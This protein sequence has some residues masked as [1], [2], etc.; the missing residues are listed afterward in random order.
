MIDSGAEMTLPWASSNLRILLFLIPVLA[1]RGAVSRDVPLAATAAG[2]SSP[3][4]VSPTQ[5]ICERQPYSFC[6]DGRGA[7]RSW[8]GAGRLPLRFDGRG[9]EAVPRGGGWQW[10]LELAAWGPSGGET[11][12]RRA[13]RPHARGARLE[14]SHDGIVEWFVQGKDGLEHG[15]TIPRR[16]EGASGA[17]RVALR[18]RGALVGTVDRDGQTVTFQTVT[19]KA[20]IRYS[21]LIVTDARG[22][23]LPARMET[24]AGSISIRFDDRGATYPV[25]VDPIVQQAYL[26]PPTVNGGGAFGTAVAVSGNTVVVSNGDNKGQVIVFVRNA[27]V[28]SQQARLNASAGAFRDLFGS[29]VAISAN[30]LVVGA[31]GENAAYVFVRN[32]TTWTQQARL[33]NSLA[34]SGFGLSV[35]ASGDTLAV[36][37]YGIVYVYTRANGV[38]SQQTMLKGLEQTS[39][40]RRLFGTSVSLSGSTLVVGSPGDPQALRGVTFPSPST[41]ADISGA[42][43]VFVRSGANWTR[44]AY[45]KASNA[46]A[47]DRFGQ[48]V[49]ISGDTIVVGAP[50]EDS[51]GTGAAAVETLSENFDRACKQM[52]NP[53]PNRNCGFQYDNTATDAGAAYVFVR[54]GGAWSQQAYLK[55]SNT[56]AGDNFG[57]TVS[58][59]GNTIVV[60]V[61]E[62][63][64][65]ATGVNG[66][67]NDNSLPKAGAAYVFI[68]TGGTWNQTDYLKASNNAKDPSLN[69]G[70][71]FGG[72]VA[73]SGDII[74]IGAVNED[75]NATGVNGNQ[76]DK[77]SQGAGAAYVFVK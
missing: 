47:G 18:V 15:F 45:F 65:N 43:Y 31:M 49:S 28:W 59:D 26:K 60:G 39:A 20:A 3:A 9:F 61:Q 68:G 21:K 77:S 51:A 58:V 17:M 70:H 12:I 73:V 66:N 41:K 44:E 6:A 56:G 19:G 40:D 57:S 32:G 4:T 2:K 42:A 36:G 38:W 50:Q 23:Q 55:A 62:E 46:A 72:A 8:S 22:H 67:Q 64:S 7:Y 14:Y 52:S 10:G 76:R 30:T 1:G 16:P 54:A 24:S 35:A 5:A 34:E 74:T 25:I 75:S 37:S 71:W 27:G 33:T 63:A 29:S 11:K 13:P 53:G 48:S 69:A